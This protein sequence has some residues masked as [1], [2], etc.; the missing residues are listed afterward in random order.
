MNSSKYASRLDNPYGQ[1]AFREVLWGE[2][3]SGASL[4]YINFLSGQQLPV[5]VEVRTADLLVQ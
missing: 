1:E 2:D 5:Y 4:W 3:P